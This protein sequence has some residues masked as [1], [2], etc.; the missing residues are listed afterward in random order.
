MLIIPLKFHNDI[1]NV[2]LNNNVPYIQTKNKL[3]YTTYMH[4]SVKLC[5]VKKSVSRSPRLLL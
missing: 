1:I 2:I 5:P 4:T 3:Q